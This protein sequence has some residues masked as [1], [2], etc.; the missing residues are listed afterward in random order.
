MTIISELYSPIVASPF[1]KI[2]KIRTLQFF[3]ATC[4]LGSFSNAAKQHE[5]DPSTISKAISRLEIELGFSLL[6]RS[7]RQ[8]RLTD[9][10]IRYLKVSREILDTLNLC[11]SQLRQD[12]NN[13]EGTL[14]IS[15]PI[16]Y[17]RLYVRPMLKAF[18]LKYPQISVE[19]LYDDAYVDIIKHKIDVAIRSGTLED[20]RLI[21]KKLSPMDFL[22]C[23][24]PAY[25]KK[26]GYPRNETEFSKHKWI[27]F[28]FKQSGLLMPTLHIVK[29]KVQESD[30][31]RSFVVD[32]GEAL[33]ELCSDGLGIAQMPH[34]VAK[35]WLQKNKIKPL[36][37]AYRP[38]NFGVYALYLD[39]T[40]MPAKVSVFLE[41]LS[42]YVKSLNEFPNST[43]AESVALPND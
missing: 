28:R 14:R 19:L 3:I 22:M 7:T 5:T 10:G 15:V 34:F 16:S 9:A 32:D 39:R 20:N 21:A 43:W 17:G 31:D 18:H 26:H 6:Q 23:A 25:I 42:N 40:Y 12:K 1:M 29:G 27:R 11:E 36:F 35:K 2:D 8:L 24:S 13:P 30:P 37:K 4:D 38:D 33:A 41:F